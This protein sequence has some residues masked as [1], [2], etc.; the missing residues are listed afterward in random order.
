V[1]R[2]RIIGE[3]WH[4]QFGGPHAE[5]NC[6]QSV[7]PADRHLIPEG[8]LYVTLEPCAHHGKTPPC[9]DL[10]VA[11]GVRQV[12]IGCTDP[13]PLVSGAGIARLQQ[14]GVE[15]LTGFMEPECRWMNRRFLYGMVNKKPYVV[16][17]WAQTADGFMAP[18]DRS[19][20]QISNRYA[21]MLAHTWRAEED[22]VLVGT[23]TALADD[24]KLSVRMVKGRAPLRIVTDRTLRLPTTLHL[25]DGTQ[26]TLVL[27]EQKEERAANVEW[28]RI[29]FGADFIKDLL[30]VLQQRPVQSLLVEGGAALLQSFI[31]AGCWQ[32]ARVIQSPVLWG[33]GLPAPVL[34]REPL[35][36]CPV[37][38]DTLFTYVNG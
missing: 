36:V 14:A 13:N 29:S 34:G 9:A 2:Q 19:R 24:P 31:E 22:A 23:Q 35:F 32:E 26:P 28:K 4:R 8:V 38:G 15:V 21:Q 37:A 3:G 11:S 10:L 5:V 1:Y 20:K 33:N 30:E 27:N 12:V 18:A 17:K 16:L 25:F 7:I 6:L